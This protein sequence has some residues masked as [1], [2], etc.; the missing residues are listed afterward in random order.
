MARTPLRTRPSHVGKAGL[1]GHMVLD[2]QD[3]SPLIQDL[4]IL[5]ISLGFP[6]S[7]LVKNLPVMQETPV[8]FLSHKDPL[9]KG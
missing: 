7:S 4:N 5:L 2:F 1:H 6:D 9:E 3:G 8:Q